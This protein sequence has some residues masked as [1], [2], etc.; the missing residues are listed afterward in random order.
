MV[1]GEDGLVGV[2]EARNALLTMP[3]VDPSLLPQGWVENHYR[4]VGVSEARNTLL[5]M[6]GVDPSLLPQGWAENH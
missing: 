2:S 6:P 1:V 4:L 3:G 5:A